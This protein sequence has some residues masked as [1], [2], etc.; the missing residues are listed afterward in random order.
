MQTNGCQEY[1]GT[2]RSFHAYGCQLNGETSA[3]GNNHGDAS[4]TSVKNIT[5][6]DRD[7]I[8]LIGQYL[9]NLGFM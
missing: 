2:V 7:I 3:A 4:E 1:N 5:K 6:T 8:R 9:R